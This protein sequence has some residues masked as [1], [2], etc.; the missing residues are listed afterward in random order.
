MTYPKTEVPMTYWPWVFFSASIMYT[1]LSYH[2]LTH[3]KEE[4][5][6]LIP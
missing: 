2:T 3:T 6:V 1:V 5:Y 4:S